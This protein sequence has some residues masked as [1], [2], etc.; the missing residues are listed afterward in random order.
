MHLKDFVAGGGDLKSKLTHESA[1]I[2]SEG[3]CARK[4]DGPAEGLMEKLHLKSSDHHTTGTN[5]GA[6]GA[7]VGSHGASGVGSHG[8]SGTN[9]GAESRAL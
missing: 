5:T 3:D 1:G 8:V 2:L 7:N 4:V 9:A 6:T